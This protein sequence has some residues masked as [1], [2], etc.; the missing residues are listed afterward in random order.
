MLW[1]T[2][3]VETHARGKTLSSDNISFQVYASQLT[4]E[5][6]QP[7]YSAIEM[8]KRHCMARSVCLCYLVSLLT[9]CAMIICLLYGR[10]CCTK[11]GHNVKNT[12]PAGRAQQQTLTAKFCQIQLRH[13]QWSNQHTRVNG[14]CFSVHPE[15]KKKSNKNKFALTECSWYVVHRL[16]VTQLDISLYSGSSVWQ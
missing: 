15:K 5:L 9:E 13:K 6:S 1:Q 11:V 10:I 3:Q 7:E 2:L 14:D 16:N 4:P 12:L 8:T